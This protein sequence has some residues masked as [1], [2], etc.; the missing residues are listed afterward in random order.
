MIAYSKSLIGRSIITF[1]WNQYFDNNPE[2]K[3][4]FYY[5]GE[6]REELVDWM[7]KTGFRHPVLFDP[8]K[9]FYSGNVTGD[10][11]AIVFNTKEG[12]VQ[13]LENPSF[14]NYQDFLDEL[15][16]NLKS[17]KVNVKVADFL[18]WRSNLAFVSSVESFVYQVLDN[19]TVSFASLNM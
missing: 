11:K 18:Q 16:E 1:D 9:V 19:C 10:T 5:S 2:I 14:P 13:F 17:T 7:K 15:K 4:I 8:E 6:N 12:V 3:F